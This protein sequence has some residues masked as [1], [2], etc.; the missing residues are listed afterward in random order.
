METVI[1]IPDLRIEFE[2]C[3][4]INFVNMKEIKL[5]Q[6]VQT[7][8]AFQKALRKMPNVCISRDGDILGVK[9]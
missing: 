2:D 5:K 4:A 3:G 6:L 9:E 8:W 7:F 1:K